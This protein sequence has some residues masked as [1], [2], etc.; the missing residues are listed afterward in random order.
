LEQERIDAIQQVFGKPPKDQIDVLKFILRHGRVDPSTLPYGTGLSQ[1]AVNLV[2][3]LGI[4]SS[5]INPAHGKA[6]VEIK[7]E[8]VRA[9]ELYLDGEHS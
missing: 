3:N 6:Y 8:L 5:I 7:P 1:N 4:S 9:M 2:L